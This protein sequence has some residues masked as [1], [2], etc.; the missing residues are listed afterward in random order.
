MG[1]LCYSGRK[2]MIIKP[3]PLFI[4]L[5]LSLAV[6]GCGGGGSAEER[7]DRGD[8]FLAED[9]VAEAIVEYRAAAQLA[10][11]SSEIHRKLGEAYLKNQDAVGA[12]RE[13]V[14]A[15]DL[16][17]D[18]IDAQLRAGQVLL[19]VG[20]FDDARARADKVLEKVPGNVEALILKG[21]SLAALKDFRGALNQV[22]EAI[23]SD[24]ARGIG[25]ARLGALQFAQGDLI[26][27][28]AAFKRAAA[29]DAES[30]APRMA[31]ANLYWSSGRR[32]E[33]ED[34]IKEA[35]RLEPT[36]VLPNQALALL[37]LGTNRLDEAEA[38]LRAVAEHA[39]TYEGQLT[40]ADYYTSRKR[41]DEAKALY[42]EVAKTRDG[43]AL[44]TLRLA[45][46]GMMQGD[47][48]SADRLIDEILAKDPNQVD[49]LVA[50]AQLQL[51]DGNLEAALATARK[52]SGA[53]QAAPLPHHVLGLV[54]KA[55]NQFED[56][57][58]A[59]KDALR[60]SPAYAPAS[61]ELAKL[62]IAAG[63]YPGAATYA[64]TALERFPGDLDAHL[65]LVRAQIAG[66]N[67]N[68]ADVSLRSLMA[69][70]PES[71][72]AQAEAGRLLMVRADASGAAA[73]FRKALERDPQQLTAIEGLVEIE[74]GQG[75][76]GLARKRL[77]AAVAAAPGNTSLQLMAARKYATSFSDLGA[78]KAAVAR[79]LDT[80]SNSVEAFDLLARI[81]VLAKDL[82]A[83]TAEFE[84]LARR[85]PKSVAYQ[86]AIGVLF[87]LQ[88]RLEDAIASYQRALALNPR[89]PVAANNLAQI[90]G[91]RNENLEVALQ[92][93]QTAKSGLPNSHEVDD[94]LGWVY[95]K[96]GDAAMALRSLKRAV[97]SQPDNPSY[98]FHLGAAYA[99]TKDTANARQ[100]LE[101]ALKVPGGFAEAA[102]ARKILNSLGG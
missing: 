82:P 92:L 27:A 83:A 21:N 75:Q 14:Q 76:A 60:A 30:A 31:L 6:A 18:D 100:A 59:F 95:Y 15:A 13:F 17:P 28:E 50:R 66:G 29:L 4:T 42:Q 5:S 41:L 22:Q 90:Y 44:A 57:E 8:R 91:D 32:Q 70:F 2:I 63:D 24:P 99:L 96:K 39:G 35:V 79:A 38:P 86:T 94:T 73:I 67:L 62:A 68:Q 33:A 87:Q 48:A 85:Q 102:E 54:Y 81:N 101:K 3:L 20:S 9:K 72:L 23:K 58:S 53:G 56:A 88:N 49:A 7:A 84:K 25:Y 77:D 26:Q 97:T 36:N 40:L 80:D 37:Y 11:D 71:P 45:S 74:L 65:L 69:T 93:A 10:P 19:L 43:Y 34:A 12:F 98:L 46:L 47:R 51:A 78:A 89:A 61:V 64:R 1:A 16:A 55:Q 52:A